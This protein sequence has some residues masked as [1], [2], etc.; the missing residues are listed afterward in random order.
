MISNISKP[1][2]KHGLN[3]YNL[4]KIFYK[5]ILLINLEKKALVI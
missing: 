5:K 4:S 3:Q 2:N 1:Y